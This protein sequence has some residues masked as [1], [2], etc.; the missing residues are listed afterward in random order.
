MIKIGD[1]E[2]I[3]S[4]RNLF[5]QI[6]YTSLSDALDLLEKRREDPVLV[7][8]INKHLNV[9]I[10]QIFKDKKCAIMARQLAT[11]NYENRTFI[12]I[13][14]KNGLDPV[15]I[16]YFNDKFTSNNKYKHSL[17]QL[18]IKN[19]IS[20]N[21]NET[22][23]KIKIVDFSKYDGKKLKDV[24]TL[25]GEPLVDFHKNLFKLYDLDNFSFFNELDWYKKN[26]EKPID[27]YV[28]FFLLVSCYG[29]L[30]ENFLW[31][32]D[33]S[34]SKFTK[35]VILP[36]IEIVENITGVKPIIVPID[37][38]D[39]ETDSFWYEHLP[40]VKEVIK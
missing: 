3:M 25:W 4:D 12:S 1:Y 15:F 32:K 14:Q 5:N 36:A 26:N 29:I 20:K 37:P 34:E 17:G 30:F 40:V 10:P 24:K 22:V 33:N 28:K 18:N 13:A 23:E 6:V 9:K 8:T 35:E 2:K 31:S 19:D 7:A 16:E 27:F 38:L 39:T 11:P 21:N